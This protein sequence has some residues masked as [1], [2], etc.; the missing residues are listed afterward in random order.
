MEILYHW[1]DVRKD[2]EDIQEILNEVIWFNKHIK[3]AGK[4]IFYINLY[5]K[6]AIRIQDLLAMN[7]T[8]YS[9][10][11]IK[12]LY[13]TNVNILNIQGILSSIPKTWKE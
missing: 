7:S 1:Y 8:F 11:E 3:V 5:D 6:G 13:S 4:S 12:A 2:P 9:S 10:A